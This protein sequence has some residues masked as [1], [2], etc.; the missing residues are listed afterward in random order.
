MRPNTRKSR[1]GRLLEVETRLYAIVNDP[2]Q[3]I[4]LEDAAVESSLM[5]EN[6]A[7]PEA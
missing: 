2:G 1:S 5:I 4:P 7:P 3:G 6:H